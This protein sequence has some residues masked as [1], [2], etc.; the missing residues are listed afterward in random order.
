MADCKPEAWATAFE[1]STDTLDIFVQK[2]FGAK[3]M[4]SKLTTDLLRSEFK[5]LPLA[6]FLLLQ[7]A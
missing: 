6:Q 7:D 1:L 4:L 3:L 5:K 2:C